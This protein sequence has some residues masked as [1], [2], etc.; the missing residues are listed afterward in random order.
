MVFARYVN[1]GIVASPRFSA[2]VLAAASSGSLRIPIVPSTMTAGGSATVETLTPRSSS[3]SA[4]R[5]AASVEAS[6]ADAS[7][8]VLTAPSIARSR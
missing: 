2:A 5:T 4:A 7:R 1:T 3:V 8:T 6:G